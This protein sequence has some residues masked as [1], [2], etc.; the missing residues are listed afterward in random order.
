MLASPKF[1]RFSRIVV[2]VIAGE[3]GR[4]SL[5]SHPSVQTAKGVYDSDRR[6][7]ARQ[8]LDGNNVADDQRQDL[9]R[10][11]ARSSRRQG[12]RNGLHRRQ[13]A[14]AARQTEDRLLPRQRRMITNPESDDRQCDVDIREPRRPDDVAVVD[15]E[16]IARHECACLHA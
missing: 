13:T 12:L 4:R 15:D 11:Q 8:G 3:S 5:P 14:A 2:G 10:W 16:L 6:E 7:R 1:R 9:R